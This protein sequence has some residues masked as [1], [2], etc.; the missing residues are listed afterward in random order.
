MY[1][2]IFKNPHVIRGYH[3]SI[4]IDVAR[5]KDYTKAV[6]AAFQ[7]DGDFMNRSKLSVGDHTHMGVSGYPFITTGA[8]EVFVNSDSIIGSIVG[9]HINDEWDRL[10]TINVDISK[11]GTI[12]SVGGSVTLS[13]KIYRECPPNKVVKYKELSWDSANTARDNLAIMKV[14]EFY[15]F[16]IRVDGGGYI[17]CDKVTKSIEVWFEDDCQFHVYENDVRVFQSKSAKET[18]KFLE[19]GDK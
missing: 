2:D 5:G 10:K 7:Q 1:A 19:T 9:N 11:I 12:R 13:G 16:T 15:A 14:N 6:K 18:A 4:N 8:G 3:R 17:R